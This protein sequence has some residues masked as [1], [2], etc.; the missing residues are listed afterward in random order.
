[1]PQPPAT[2]I[3]MLAGACSGASGMACTAVPDSPKM[4]AKAIN[5]FNGFLPVWQW[6]QAIMEQAAAQRKE[7]IGDFP[8]ALGASRAWRIIA[9]SP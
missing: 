3:V 8:T 4:N 1:M 2:W 7:R 5:L 6:P 9:S